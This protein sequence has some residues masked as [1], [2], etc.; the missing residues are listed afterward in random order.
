MQSPASL[1]PLETAIG[2]ESIQ[3][4]DAAVLSHISHGRRVSRERS[5]SVDSGDGHYIIQ[6]VY[7]KIYG[8]GVISSILE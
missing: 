8:T 5:V 1:L 6:G 4:R 2:L 7:S 3:L